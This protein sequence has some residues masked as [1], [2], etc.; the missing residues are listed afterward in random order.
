MILLAEP[1]LHAYDVSLMGVHPG[2]NPSQPV[3]CVEPF[4]SLQWPTCVYCT[5]VTVHSAFQAD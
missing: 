4:S 2:H 3:S 5:I 1:K